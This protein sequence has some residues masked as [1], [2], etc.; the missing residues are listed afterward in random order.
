MRIPPAVGSLV[1]VLAA[2]AACAHGDLVAPDGPLAGEWGGSQGSLVVDAEGADVEIACAFGRIEG[3]I[4]L[5]V[6]RFEGV[7]PWWPGPAPPEEPF[8]ARYDGEVDGRLLTLS[9][10]VD[11]LAHVYGPVTLVLGADPT[12]PRC[13]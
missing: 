11:E 13:Q 12:F 8:A 2:A 1:A 6:G 3:P 7:G 5:A 4:V 9:I 10:T